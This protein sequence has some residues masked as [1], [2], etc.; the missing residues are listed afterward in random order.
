MYN[1]ETSNWDIIWASWGW[2]TDFQ[3][4]YS[5]N[6]R[7]LIKS[8]ANPFGVW[9]KHWYFKKSQKIWVQHHNVQLSQNMGLKR[10]KYRFL[11]HF[12][13]EQMSVDNIK[14]YPIWDLNQNSIFCKTPKNLCTTPKYLTE[15]EYGPHRDEI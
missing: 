2:N 10:L 1:I 12:C 5:V 11:A 7:L 9:A 15:I 6:R 14:I 3:L 13:R 8:K 4:V